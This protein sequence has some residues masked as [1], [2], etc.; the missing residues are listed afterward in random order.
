MCN[1]PKNKAARKSPMTSILINN[2]N[3]E[4]MIDTGAS[5]NVMDE[6]T[7]DKIHK[8]TLLRHRGPR[9]MPYGGGTSLNVLGVCDV[10][11]ESKSAIQCHRFHVIK[12]AHGSLVGFTA[13]QELGH[14]N[15]VNKINSKWEIKHPGLTKGV[16][17]LKDVQVKHP[18]H[19]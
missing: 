3:D 4:M 17:K 14:V 1:S 19:R 7:Y 6:E 15:I 16:G 11:L 10:T 13:A 18:S 2:V 12:D 8:P 5:V 9:F